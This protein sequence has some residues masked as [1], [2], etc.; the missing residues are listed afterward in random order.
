MQKHEFGMVK[1]F[2][3]ITEENFDFDDSPAWMRKKIEIDILTSLYG[4]NNVTVL[5]PATENQV[6][7]MLVRLEPH[8]GMEVA[9]CSIELLMSYTECDSTDLYYSL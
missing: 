1:Q 3:A 4:E 2:S 6:G 5:Q 8:S 7:S 9:G